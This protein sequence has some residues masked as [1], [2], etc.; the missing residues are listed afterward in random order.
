M[1]FELNAVGNSAIVSYE[2][3]KGIIIYRKSID[4]FCVYDLACTNDPT[5]PCEKVEKTNDNYVVKCSCCGSKFLLYDGYPFEGPA[6]H[7]LKSYNCS[8]DGD[9]TLSIFN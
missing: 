3:Y 6:K 8:Y 9:N 7:P 5:K 2:G 4:E 1:Y